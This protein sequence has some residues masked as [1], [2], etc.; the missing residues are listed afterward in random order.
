[1]FYPALN[2]LNKHLKT[3]KMKDDCDSYVGN[4]IQNWNTVKKQ[5]P[6]AL[7]R[8]SSYKGDIGLMNCQKY[9]NPMM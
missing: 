3:I 8:I 7:T 6:P 2:I 5:W 4:V 9:D 1:L